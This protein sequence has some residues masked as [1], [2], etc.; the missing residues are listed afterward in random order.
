MGWPITAKHKY[1]IIQIDL[2]DMS[3]ILS[4]DN[5]IKCLMTK[6]HQFCQVAAESF[7]QVSVKQLE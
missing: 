5:G 1:D 3:D 6:G 4:S 7:V 2:V